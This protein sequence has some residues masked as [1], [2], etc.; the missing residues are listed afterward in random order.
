[1]VFH[2]SVTN[3]DQFMM[4]VTHSPK[5]VSRDRDALCRDSAIRGDG[6]NSLAQFSISSPAT[7]SVWSGEVGFTPV[8]ASIFV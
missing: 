5:P 6:V 3:L 8:Y 7:V 1:M 4:A 2:T